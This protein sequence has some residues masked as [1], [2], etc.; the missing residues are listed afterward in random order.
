M[1]KPVGNYS[2]DNNLL[3]QE[4]TKTWGVDLGRMPKCEILYLIS[5]ITEALFIAES[6]DSELSLEIEEVVVRFPEELEKWEAIQLFQC[7]LQHI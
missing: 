2:L 3:V 5:A 1:T 7:L 6:D 4:M